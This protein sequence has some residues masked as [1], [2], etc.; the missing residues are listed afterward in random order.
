MGKDAR[1]ISHLMPEQYR[2]SP[3]IQMISIERVGRQVDNLKLL[4]SCYEP[5]LKGRI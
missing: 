2:V 4:S 5:F 3:E 1:M